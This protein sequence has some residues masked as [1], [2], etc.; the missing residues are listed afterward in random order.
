MSVNKEVLIN[1]LSALPEETLK[2]LLLGDLQNNKHQIADPRTGTLPDAYAG[3]IH[4]QDGKIPG[5]N[6]GKSGIQ[7]TG[8]STGGGPGV[9]GKP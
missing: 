1:L 7:K 6:R 8:C 3:G 9:P 5:K 2:R 4:N